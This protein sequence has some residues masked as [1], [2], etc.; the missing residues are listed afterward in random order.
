MIGFLKKKQPVSLSP[1]IG[2][3][4]CMRC[5]VTWNHFPV[6]AIHVVAMGNN[7]GSFALCDGCWNACSPHQR[8]VYHVAVW[9]EQHMS[10]K[11]ILSCGDVRPGEVADLMNVVRCV[12]GADGGIEEG[13]NND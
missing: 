2:F 13:V 9:A 7:G 12:M 10:V 1:D 6:S 5:G 8:L 3:S 11:S 4:W